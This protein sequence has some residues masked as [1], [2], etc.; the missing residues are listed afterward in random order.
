MIAFAGHTFTSAC[1]DVVS[2]DKLVYISL[3]RGYI[4]SLDLDL[5]PQ[6][7]MDFPNTPSL[8]GIFLQTMPDLVTPLKGPSIFISAQLSTDAVSALRKLWVLIIED[9]GS[10]L[11]P[12]HALKHET[13]PPRVKKIEFHLD[14]NDFG[15]I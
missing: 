1:R 12:K 2:R 11:A 10:T 9:C 8:S 15:F 14:S 3:A 5:T 7:Y 4:P 13:H 6:N